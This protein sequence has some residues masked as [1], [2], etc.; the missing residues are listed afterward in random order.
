MRQFVEPGNDIA[1]TELNI[2]CL[3]Q[4]ERLRPILEYAATYRFRHAQ[5]DP[6]APRAGL[7]GAT[8][9]RSI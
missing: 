8:S 2:T 4:V 3:D 5:T 9:L 7:T 1:L 6:E